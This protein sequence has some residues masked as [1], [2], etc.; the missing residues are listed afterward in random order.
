M[1]VQSVGDRR[2]LARVAKWRSPPGPSDILSK[3]EN[4]GPF[5]KVRGDNLHRLKYYSDNQ[6]PTVIC[7]CLIREHL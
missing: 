3:K 7:S 5:A 1:S 6:G 2:G 4:T